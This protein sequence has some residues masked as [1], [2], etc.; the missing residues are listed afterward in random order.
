[1]K[2]ENKSREEPSFRDYTKLCNVGE[3]EGMLRFFKAEAAFDK[4][5]MGEWHY[6]YDLYIR[7]VEDQL[8]AMRER[9]AR[10]GEGQS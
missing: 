2:R 4:G 10:S 6:P 7:I 8:A 5:T 1:M 3:L 9:G